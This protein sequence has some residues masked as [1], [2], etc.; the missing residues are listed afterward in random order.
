MALTRRTRL[1]PIIADAVSLDCWSLGLFAQTSPETKWIVFEEIRTATQHFGELYF[2]C[3]LVLVSVQQ[4]S[5]ISLV[6][7]YFGDLRKS[8][9]DINGPMTR[10]YGE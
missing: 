4:P 1:R 8:G 5:G 10:C 3:A 6:P 9:V 7:E 2:V